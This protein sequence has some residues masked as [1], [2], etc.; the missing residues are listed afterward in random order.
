MW[1]I[2]TTTKQFH[3]QCHDLEGFKNVNQI[4]HHFIDPYE[5]VFGI[6][7]CQKIVIH[8]IQ[9]RK[10]TSLEKKK[11]PKSVKVSN[12]P[13]SKRTVS[14]KKTTKIHNKPKKKVVYKSSHK[15]YRSIQSNITNR[16]TELTALIISNPSILF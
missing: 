15:T 2:N 8:S 13:K 11:K 6:F 1:F 5:C 12:P 10:N 9:S 4:I 3:T 14:K 16:T 7:I